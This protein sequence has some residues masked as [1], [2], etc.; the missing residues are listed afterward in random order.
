MRAGHYRVPAVFQHLHD[1]NAWPTHQLL[2]KANLVID[3][4]NILAEGRTTNKSSFTQIRTQLTSHGELSQACEEVL[5]RILLAADI[6]QRRVSEHTYP[7]YPWDLGHADPFPVDPAGSSGEPAE[8]RGFVRLVPDRVA[9]PDEGVAAQ[10]DFLEFLPPDLLPLY[11]PDSRQALRRSPPRPDQIAAIPV[12]KGYE[13]AHYPALIQKFVDCGMFGLQKEKPKVINGLFGA[14]KDVDKDRLIADCRRGN[15][16]FSDP[17]GV[18]LPTP[19]DIAD[20]VISAPSPE[21]CVL[22][23]AKADVNA[24][25]HR[26]RLP[27][28]M[29]QFFGFPPIVVDGE[30][31][32]PVS[33]TLPMGFSHAVP[34]AHNVHLQIVRPIFSQYKVTEVGTNVFLDVPPQRSALV[35]YIDDNAQLSLEEKVAKVNRLQDRMIDKLESEGLMMSPSKVIR[36]QHYVPETDVLGMAILRGGGVYPKASRMAALDYDTDKMIHTRRASSRSL[37]SITGRW[38]WS[39]LIARPSLSVLQTVYAYIEL[40]TP[41]VRTLSQESVAEL[42]TLVNLSPLLSANLFAPLGDLIMATDASL[43][44]AGVCVAEISP[45]D[46]RELYSRRIRKGWWSAAPLGDEDGNRQVL[47]YHQTTADIVAKAEWRTVVAY[48]FKFEESRIVILEAQALLTGLRWLVSNP[49]HFGRRI[50][51][52]LDSQSLLGAVVK[53]RSSSRRLNRLCR[54]MAA[55]FLVTQIKPAYIWIPSEFN[56]ADEPSRVGGAAL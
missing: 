12:T 44:G 1:G 56:P 40:D 3:T 28:W 35:L 31:W 23:V 7:P 25:Y 4:V 54:K 27:E 38:V 43:T 36:A 49:A 19:A 50:I 8:K 18:S 10:V 5:A 14:T 30:T 13:E 48:N 53:G 22:C 55:F 9:I 39:C 21:Q 16:F 34:I 42:Q 33:F 17:P 47:D 46:Y 6:N 52:F 45:M 51:F 41:E 11:H 2:D 24:F 15:L 37:G 26:L 20:L 29:R 32:W